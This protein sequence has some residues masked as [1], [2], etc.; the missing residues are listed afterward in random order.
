MVE[1]ID[2]G[3]DAKWLPARQIEMAVALRKSLAFDFGHEPG[4]IAQPV[5]GPDH[6]A[7]HADDGVAGIDRI[8][9]RQCIGVFLDAV[10]EQLQAPRA[11]F[12]RHAR[13]FL[14]ACL[15]RLHRGVDIRFARRRNSRR[16][17][18][19]SMD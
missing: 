3:D 16:G 19:Y 11:L 15:G 10:G 5:G 17:F 13:P 2:L 12:D 18:P 4:A 1:R 6:V 7:A 9:Q 14:E 8:K